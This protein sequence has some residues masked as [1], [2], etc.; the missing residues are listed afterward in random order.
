M[1]R[2][3]IAFLITPGLEWSQAELNKYL[4]KKGIR[5]KNIFR[6]DRRDTATEIAKWN[7]RKKIPNRNSSGILQKYVTSLFCLYYINGIIW[8]ITQKLFLGSWTEKLLYNPSERALKMLSFDSNFGCIGS[9]GKVWKQLYVAKQYRKYFRFKVKNSFCV[10]N[11]YKYLLIRNSSKRFIL[12][13]YMY[14]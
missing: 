10:I 5:C 9:R 4:F 1:P 11:Q 7:S 12:Y 14:S 13:M 3:A 2:N 8:L 6:L